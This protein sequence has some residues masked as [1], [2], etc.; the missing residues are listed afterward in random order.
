MTRT[1]STLNRLQTRLFSRSDGWIGIEMGCHCIHFAQVS[2]R[3]NRWQ[4]SAIWSLEHPASE[5][6]ESNDPKRRTDEMF[7]WVARDEM[8]KNGL[9][10]TLNTEDLRSLFLGRR[11]AT[12]LTD[13]MIAYRELELP[14]ANPSEANEMVRSE[15]AIETDL[16]IEELVTD[17]WDLPQCDSRVGLCSFGA[18]SI[19]KTEVSHVASS[20]LK[21]GFECQ[22]MDALP[23]AMARSTAMVVTDPD[24][25]TLAV[26]LGYQQ[27][28]LTLVKAGRPVLSRELRGLGV[29]SLLDQIADAF[30][31]S[32]SD[33]QTLLFQPSSKA[34]NDDP[35]KLAFSNPIHQYLSSFFQVLAAEIDKTIQFATRA[36]R[37]AVPSQ[38]LMMG[39]GSRICNV[40]RSMEDRTG[41]SARFWSID[42]SD[43]LFVD[44]PSSIY[45]V[46]AGL[47]T[48]AWEQM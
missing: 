27:A 40:D 17:C 45:A 23:C 14:S 2:K 9:A 44:K 43:S 31:L 36:Y 28:T 35:G 19:K 26:D 39:A 29:V 7:G 3:E 47:S 46:A 18:V 37:F 30:E 24:T 33:A 15:I 6:R 16:D 1:L 32:R 34:A 48:L 25:S 13:G 41:L 8:F 5:L 11:C 21:A 22:T 20:L 10:K 42:Q 4:L 12:T 38:L